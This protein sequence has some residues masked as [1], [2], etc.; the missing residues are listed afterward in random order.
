[1]GIAGQTCDQAFIVLAD[2]EDDGG[3]QILYADN[4]APTGVCRALWKLA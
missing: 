3:A 1:M 4:F 2:V